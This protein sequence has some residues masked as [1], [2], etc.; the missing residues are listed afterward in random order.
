MES[1]EAGIVQEKTLPETPKQNVLAERY[2]R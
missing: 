1:L 2:N